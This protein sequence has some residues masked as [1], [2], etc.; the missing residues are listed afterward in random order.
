MEFFLSHYILLCFDL[1]VFHRNIIKLSL[2]LVNHLCV[3]H[4]TAFV[5]H[6]F[7][8]S[9]LAEVIVRNNPSNCFFVIV[10]KTEATD[11]R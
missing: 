2:Y 9:I 10:S 3:E 11:K 1:V 5:T 4:F 7:D 6:D 8:H